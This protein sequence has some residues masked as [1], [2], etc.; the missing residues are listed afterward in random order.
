MVV[1]KRLS[2]AIKDGD[3]VLGVIAGS[4]ANQN[5]NDSLI[6]VPHSG[7]QTELYRDVLK[8]SGLSSEA[9]SYVEAHGTGTGVGDPVEV[10]S[11]RDVFGGPQRDS[12]LHFSSIKGNIGHTEGTAGVVGL[13]KV[14]LMMRNNLIPVQASH[15]SLNPKIPPL[16]QDRVAIPRKVL[17]WNDPFRAACVNSYG[18]AG[19]NAALM[20]LEK[21]STGTSATPPNLS[22]WPLIE[23][24]MRCLIFLQ[25]Q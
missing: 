19:S 1:L 12:L 21:P 23:P 3:N 13:V 14:L 18:A 7:S 5:H 25:P 22:Q 6:T 24:I 9:V 2:D 8:L 20:I 17:P 4:A 16:D 15:K 10:R 11:I